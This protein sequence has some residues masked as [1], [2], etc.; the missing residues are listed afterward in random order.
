MGGYVTANS[1]LIFFLAWFKECDNLFRIYRE[2][3]YA[4]DLINAIYART[5]SLNARLHMEI[6]FYISL[7]RRV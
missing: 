3:T 6:Q 2:K 4:G 5:L 7:F 1:Q